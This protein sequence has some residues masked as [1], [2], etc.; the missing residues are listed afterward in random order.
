L[1]CFGVCEGVSNAA[2][3]DERL[4]DNQRV[5]FKRAGSVDRDLSK[6]LKMSERAQSV[7]MLHRHADTPCRAVESI[8]SSIA[9][10]PGKIVTVA[11]TLTGAVEQ[12]RIPSERHIGKADKL[13]QHTCFELFIGAKNDA[14]YYEFNFSPSGQ[15]AAYEF[16][17]YRDGGPLDIDEVEPKIALQRAPETLELTAVCRLH[18]LPSI[19]AGVCL[20]L[21][22]SAV[23]EDLDGQLSYWALKHPPGK[24]DFHHSDT[25]ALD[26]S[27][28]G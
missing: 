4:M 8:K 3:I 14:E 24:P 17:D 28:A 25:F 12:L 21:G 15:W 2:H 5:F 22:L 26:L 27:L 9:C 7:V 19:Q 20:W 1:A 23:I 18:R 10:K 13:W 11:Y 6:S 16:R